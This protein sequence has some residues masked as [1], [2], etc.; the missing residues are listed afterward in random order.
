MLIMLLVLVVIGG[1]L[2]WCVTLGKI[3]VTKAPDLKR[4]TVVVD[5]ETSPV[6]FWALWAG[7]VIALIIFAVA[8]FRNFI[9]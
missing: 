6:T 3:Y 7:S 4:Q 9:E 8:L 5:S 1:Y 2:A